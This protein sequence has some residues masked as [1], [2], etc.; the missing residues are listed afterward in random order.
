MITDDKKKINWRSAFEIFTRV[1]SWVVI[2]IVVALTIGKA[3]DARYGTE[4]WIFLSLTVVSFAISSFGIVRVVTKYIKE[5]TPEIC[6]PKIKNT[7]SQI[8][9]EIEK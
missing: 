8:T 1:S 6:E 7:E 4:P 5:F 3:L 2:P 9:E